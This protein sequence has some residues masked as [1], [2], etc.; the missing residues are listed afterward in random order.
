VASAARPD[1]ARLTDGLPD[2]VVPSW[3]DPVAVQASEAVGGP[4]GRHAVT[5]RALFWT[6]L[7]I[8]LLFTTLVLAAAWIKQV[9]CASGNWAGFVQYTHFCYSDGVPLFTLRGLGSGQV[10]YLDSPVEYPVLTGGFMALAAGISGGYDGLARSFGLL[11][12]VPAVESYYVVTCLLLSVCAFLTT[13]AVL[14][15]S[16]RRPWDAAMFALSPL[17]FVHAFTNWDL[18]AVALSTLGLWAWARSRPAV[19]GVLIGLGIAAKLYPVLLLGVLF[20]LC[21]RAGRLR[22][23]LRA[24]V[25]AGV[26]WLVVNAPI[27]VLA[28]ANW[29][30]FF[31]L[32]GSR[33]ADPDTIWNLLLAA[34]DQRLFDGPLAEGQTPAVLNLVIAVVLLLFVLGMAWLALAAPVRPRVAQLAFLLVA[35]FLLLNKVW[36]PQYSLW[37][38]PLAVLARPKW[39]SLLLWQAT[40][41]LLWVPR[42]LWYLGTQN[43]GIEVEWFF[44]A[45]GIRDV[46]VV[47]L[48]ALVVRD[49][50]RPD[51]DVVRRS[52]PGVDDPAG[53]V[54]DHAPDRVVLR[55]R[56]SAEGLAEGGDLSGVRGAVAGGLED[57]GAA[58]RARH[59][60]E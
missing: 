46:A 10:P 27:A 25:A 32:N 30:R 19:A 31:A 12:Q 49:I 28:P 36:S 8:C 7:R 60:D 5:G 18:F 11:P 21:L 51:E 17:L 1:A 43:K 26:T 45:V 54:L 39:R 15:A 47:T 56:S 52:W 13:R 22:P 6:P 41:A 44:L 16:G 9:P 37:L 20:L 58:G 38:L 59:P 23:W 35:G 53:G 4:W 24:A 14:G 34:T 55:R 3:V 42:L 50:L 40:E 29:G 33:P 57:D 2:R 48:M